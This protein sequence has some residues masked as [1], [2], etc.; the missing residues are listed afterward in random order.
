MK[1]ITLLLFLLLPNLA[2]ANKLTRV[3]IPERDLLNL[4]FERQA[5]LIVERL[6]SGDIVGNG[7]GLIEQNFMSA[8]YNIQSA[9]QVCLNSYGCVDTEQERLLLR[10][11]N[12]VYIEKINQERPILFVSEDIAGDF[13]KSEDDQTARVAKTGFSPETKIFVNLEEATLIAN[14][15]PAMLGILVHELGHQ[16]GV[17][18]HSFLDQLGAKVRNLWEDNLSI[19]RI[20]MKREELDVQLFASELNYTTSKIQ[21]T[22]KDET[23]SINPLIFNK[24]ECGDDEIVYG[25]NLSNGHWDR[26]H[27]VQTRTRVRL[28]FWIDIYCQAIDGEI[29]SEQRDLNL[30]F[31]FNSFNRNRPILRTIRARIN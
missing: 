18:S 3:S 7:G 8:Y 31:N 13:F 26:P 23:K 1:H 5:A 17:A 29:R 14:N 22:Y 9:I 11:I 19:Y 4:E 6:G 30:T 16:A 24:I 28:N 10:E 21:Y 20:E 2:S 27:Q 25:F 15:I 12:Q